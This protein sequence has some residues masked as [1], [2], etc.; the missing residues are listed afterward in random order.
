MIVIYL[1]LLSDD[2]TLNDRAMNFISGS[3]NSKSRDGA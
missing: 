2:I 3:S 1:A